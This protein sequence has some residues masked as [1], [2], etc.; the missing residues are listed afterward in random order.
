[1]NA[2]G[3]DNGSRGIDVGAESGQV[4]GRDAR[5]GK[6]RDGAETQHPEE[7]GDEIDAIG[8][9]KEYARAGPDAG[10]MEAAGP[11]R[12][13]GVERAI[14]AAIVA[15]DDGRVGTAAFA[16]PRPEQVGVEVQDRDDPFSMASAL[17]TPGPWDHTKRKMKQSSTA[18]SPWF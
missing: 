17:Q 2:S 12:G 7:R 9:R 5:V 18:G 16:Q 6:S 14:A 15:G 13:P 10:A 1:M 4:A 8:Q 3:L 11:G